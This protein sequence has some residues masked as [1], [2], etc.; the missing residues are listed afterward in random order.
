MT[1]VPNLETLLDRRSNLALNFDIVFEPESGCLVGTSAIGVV[2]VVDQY[3]RCVVQ[4]DCI[5][6]PI[7]PLSL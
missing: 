1:A 6:S 2:I 5:G 3:M 7:D 4:S